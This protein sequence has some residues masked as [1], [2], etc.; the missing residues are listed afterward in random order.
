MS[1]ENKL[2]VLD[3]PDQIEA[4]RLLSLK[5]ALNLETKGLQMSRGRKASVMVREVLTAAGKKAPANKVKLLAAYVEHLTE[6][7]VYIPPAVKPVQG[8]GVDIR[9]KNREREMRQV[10]GE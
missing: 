10:N 9:D 7:G 1:M 6:I 2:I 8:D 3:K 4:F 5:G